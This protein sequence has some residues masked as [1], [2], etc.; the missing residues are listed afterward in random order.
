MSKLG[1][2]AVLAAAESTPGQRV[3]RFLDNAHALPTS[4]AA[5]TEVTPTGPPK[6]AADDID[7]L[8]RELWDRHVGHLPPPSFADVTEVL[9]GD[10]LPPLDRA[11]VDPTTLT[12][13]QR[14]WWQHGYVV[15]K[16]FIPDDILDAYYEVRSRLDRP[17]GWESPAPY[18]HVPEIRALGLYG[19][20]ANLLDELIG[21][22]MAM[23]LNLTGWLSTERNWHQDDY[24]NPPGV[25]GWY[26]AVWIAVRD[27]DPQSGPFQ[28]VPGSHRWPVLRRE[29]V[30][31][32]LTPE[33]RAHHDWPRK[34]E[35]FLNDL[36]E[37]ELADRGAEVG[38]FT[39]EMG[40]VL[41]WHARLVHRG[42]PPAVPGTP[43]IGFISHYTGVNHW[44]GSPNIGTHPGGGRYF[45]QDIPLP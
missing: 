39:A 24:L 18:M 14:H 35:R 15:K 2:R 36:L 37:K 3:L 31:L 16:R 27:I 22:P 43:R 28:Y 4:S 13:D 8:R 5:A 11:G 34:T 42:S 9:V 32:F 29:R 10:F 21:E 33:E 26:A 23:T 7:E 45:L 38:T 19:P 25:Q 1:R 40:D 41:I 12:D 20:L 6:P 30:R 44:E 17:H